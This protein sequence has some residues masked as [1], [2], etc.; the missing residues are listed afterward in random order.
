MV[1]TAPAAAP[2]QPAPPPATGHPPAGRSPGGGPARLFRR[3]ADWPGWAPAGAALVTLAVT[4]WKIQVPSFWRDEAATQSATLRSFTG[5]IA[6]LG[7][8]D[9]VHGAYYL[10]IWLE[11]RLAGR[12][13]LAL[14]LPSALAMVAAAALITVT[15]RRLVSG[16]AGLAA[17][18]TFAALPAVSWFA[19]DA[20]PFALET[21]A[22][23]AASYFLVR[24][25]EDG[26]RGRWAA[27]YAA[28]LV[29]L[30]LTNL[31]G[32]LLIPAHAVTVAAWPGRPSRPAL[33][34]RWLRAA[35]AACVALVP[36]MAAA[37]G[38][39][40]QVGWLRPP[41]AAAALATGRLVGSAGLLLAAVVLTGLGLA[42]AV[43]GR[44]VG[45]DWPV[46]L[47]ALCLPWLVLPA[48]MLFAAAQIQP[49]Y[50][51]RYIVFCTP[52]AALLIG[53]G[54][55]AAGRVAGAAGLALIVLLALPAQL[56]ERGPS[57]HTDNIRHL[58]QIVARYERPGDA[59]LYPQAGM[60]TFAA[61]YPYGLIRLHDVMLGESAARSGTISG[62]DAPAP[63]VRAR[64]GGVTRV[65]VI[66]SNVPS[67]GRPAE[68]QGLPFRLVRT[69]QVTV[70]WLCLY[71]YQA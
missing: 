42:Y 66:R 10:L 26:G 50:T 44:R 60:R 71:T 69:W 12:S 20:R 68:L 17:G 65:W 6:M 1:A 35:I 70:S 47:P 11:M 29:V 43:L 39:R 2:P 22:G 49:A 63:V 27:C 14:R 8:V 21:A 40:G 53:T 15:G 24:L 28:S 59:V 9:V 51:F 52:A 45:A 34:R 62:L 7:H 46:R 5:L 55:A 18:L 25:A 58:D 64:L 30:G 13:E 48:L 33:A 61:A 67:P 31:F 16:R 19:Q 23:A 3:L 57:G 37:W 38:Q 54:L 36:L 56:G 4:S 32:L 41:G